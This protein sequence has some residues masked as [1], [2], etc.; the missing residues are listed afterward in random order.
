MKHAIL[1]L[2]A[3]SVCALFATSGCGPRDPSTGRPGADVT[4][5]DGAVRPTIDCTSDVGLKGKVVTANASLGKLGLGMGGGYQ[6]G[7]V[8]QVTDSTYQL[9][10]QL[11]SLCKDYNACAVDPAGYSAAS[12]EIRAQ[13][14][15]HLDLVGRLE[16]AGSASTDETL[17]DTIWENARPDLAK[18]RL[19]VEYRVEAVPK[20]GGATQ[21]HRDEAPLKAGDGFRI[22]LRPS[23]DAHV[24]VLMMSSQGAP[25]LLYPDAS[26]GLSNPA[27]GGREIVI[28]PDGLFVL[29]DVAGEEALEILVSET[30]LTDLEARLATLGSGDA[31]GPNVLEPVAELLCPPSG[32]RGVKYTKTTAVCGARRHRGVLYTKTQQPQIKAV[33]GDGVVVLQHVVT[34]R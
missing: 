32:K 34:H 12:S 3:L 31:A 6:E 14:G 17:G 33:P 30:P 13:L 8:G 16:G 25:T 22:V 24:Y 7:A 2:A 10:L 23:A 21:L 11:E 19:S 26:M 1:R 29:D 4:C 9:A 28:P 15:T 18:S 20:G 5:P 27:A